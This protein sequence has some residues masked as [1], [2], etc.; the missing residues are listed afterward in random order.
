VFILS[1]QLNLLF[2]SFSCFLDKTVGEDNLITNYEKVKD[3]GDV[4][5]KLDSQFHQSIPQVFGI[6]FPKRVPV[7]LQYLNAR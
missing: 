2:W 3:S 7:F 6:G 4:A 5:G 1:G